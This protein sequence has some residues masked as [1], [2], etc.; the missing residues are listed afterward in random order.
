M[1]VEHRIVGRMQ[2]DG[3]EAQQTAQALL[4]RLRIKL[5]PTTS[6]FSGRFM[7]SGIRKAC[8]KTVNRCCG[9]V[10]AAE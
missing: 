4:R 2:Q 8:V 9:F 10:R 6:T 3:A 7:K 5:I 1:Q